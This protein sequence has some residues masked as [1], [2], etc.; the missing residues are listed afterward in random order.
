[1]ILSHIIPRKKKLKSDNSIVTKVEEK[2]DKIVENCKKIQK[3]R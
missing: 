3:F 1:M 2:S